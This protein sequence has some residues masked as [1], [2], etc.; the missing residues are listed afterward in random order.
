GII[1]MW[2]AKDGV[3]AKPTY[4]ITTTFKDGVWGTLSEPKWTSQNHC[5]LTEQREYS[6]Q[7]F[8]SVGDDLFYGGTFLWKREQDLLRPIPQNDSWL[9]GIPTCMVVNSAGEIWVGSEKG[10]DMYNPTSGATL[11]F[12]TT[13]SPLVGSH[14]YHVAWDES[15]QVLWART[16]CGFNRLQNNQWTFIKLPGTSNCK[17]G[18]VGGMKVDVDGALWVGAKG[19][20][21]WD[22]NNW[23]HFT[24]ENSAIPTVA[25]P[26]IGSQDVRARFVRKDGSLGVTIGTGGWMIIEREGTWK[27][28]NILAS[29]VGTPH[30]NGKGE[31][32]MMARSALYE[33]SQQTFRKIDYNFDDPYLTFRSFENLDENA[34][35]ATGYLYENQT[36]KTWGM[37]G[38]TPIDEDGIW[39]MGGEELWIATQEGVWNITQSDLRAQVLSKG[40][41]IDKVRVNETSD[42]WQ[43]EEVTCQEQWEVASTTNE[44]RL[45]VAFPLA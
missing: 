29:H 41:E 34:W 22:G 27:V 13:N 38:L 31:L 39:T 28:P 21:R 8:T 40:K 35:V 15:Q 42:P 11:H 33:I 3:E 4:G 16:S 44:Q 24:Q 37:P 18:L 23:C 32:V 26:L 7:A 20:W 10:L 30:F 5:S 17:M 36:M 14:V 2:E 45:E 25:D 43:E 12:D 19:M 1:Y 6:I 9:S